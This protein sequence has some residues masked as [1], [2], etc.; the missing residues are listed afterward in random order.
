MAIFRND[1]GGSWE[2]LVTTVSSG[3]EHASIP[4]VD[5]G[6]ALLADHSVEELRMSVDDWHPNEVAHRL[7][8]E[9]LQRFFERHE[10][11]RSPDGA[12]D[13]RTDSRVPA[14]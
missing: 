7:A 11:L 3:L 10:I 4:V 5:L 1:K 12:S 8:A 14:P 6:I 13:S 2:N 9:E